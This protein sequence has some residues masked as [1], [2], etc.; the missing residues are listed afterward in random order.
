MKR[1]G[2]LMDSIFSIGGVQ[3]VTAVIAKELA[4]EYDVTIITLDSPS[5]KNTS[6]YGLEEANI[7]YRFFHYPEV[8]AVKEKVCKAYSWIYRKVLPQTHLASDLY[9]HSS[10]PSEKRNAL[11]KELQQGHYDIIIGDHA[12]LAVTQKP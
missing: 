10:F 4:K 5:V 1:I 6:L 12:P 9:A 2:I 7:N 3:R 11:A 8:G